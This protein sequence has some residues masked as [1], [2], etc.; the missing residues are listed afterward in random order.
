MTGTWAEVDL[1]KLE[2]NF[3]V[4]KALLKPGVKAL[5]IC[6][7]NAYGHGLAEVA[8]RLEQCGA[9]MLAIARVS[10]GVELRENNIKSEIL[11]L[12]EAEPE[13]AA[14][15]ANNNI[16]QAVGSLELAEKLSQEALSLNKIINIHV[17]LDTGMSRIG[18]YVPDDVKAR[19]EI[20]N[21]ILKLKDLKGL[22]IKGMFSHFANAEGDENYTQSQIDK[23]KYVKDSLESKGLKLGTCH[24][25]ASDALIL[26][27]ASHFDMVRMGIAL[28]GYKSCVT[29]NVDSNLGLKPA[30]KLKSRISSVRALPKGT[31]IGYGCTH[32]LTRDSVIAVLQVGY[33][34][35]LPR[36]LSNKCSVKIN[37]IKCKVLGRIFMDMCMADVTDLIN[38]NNNINVNVGD[39]A[40]VYDEELI[41]DAAR[42]AGT[43]IHEILCLCS[44]PRI[45]HVYLN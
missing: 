21:K 38:N 30:M 14:L 26:N 31:K 4:L 34:D 44:S 28:Y 6:K 19:G 45:Q 17:K 40:V 41:V 12:G 18:F 10:E 35:G 9:D 3:K 20:I 5:A 16:T 1:S 42:N 8:K 13:L 22:N 37:N 32:E 29:G 39:E 43:V 27:Q 2:H 36:I 24:I 33:A 11:C 15:I 23:F 7:A 25:A